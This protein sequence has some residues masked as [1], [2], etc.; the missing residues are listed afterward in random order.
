MNPILPYVSYLSKKQSSGDSQEITLNLLGISAAAKA[1]ILGQTHHP[2]S[3]AR[4]KEIEAPK[5]V[6]AESPELKKE[7]SRSF[8]KYYA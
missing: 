5:A 7:V 8:R 3:V 6:P 2:T 4:I 1:A